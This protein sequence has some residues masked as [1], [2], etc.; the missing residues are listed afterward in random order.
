MHIAASAIPMMSA[1]APFYYPRAA[2][3]HDTGGVSLAILGGCTAYLLKPT[4]CL[5]TGCVMFVAGDHEGERW[6]IYRGQVSHEHASAGHCG[7]LPGITSLP[8]LFVC[9]V[10]VLVSLSCLSVSRPSD[11]RSVCLTLRL[12]AF[13]H[14]NLSVCVSDCMPVCLP[15]CL[16]VCLSD[17]P[18]VCPSVCLTVRLLAFLHNNLS[19]CMSVCLIV[20]LC[21]CLPVCLSV[22]LSVCLSGCLSICLPDSAFACFSACQPSCLSDCLP[23]C[24]ST[25]LSICL[26]LCPSVSGRQE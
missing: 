22:W 9:P 2:P 20:C 23:A 15:A 12:L 19:V 5:L 11:V 1:T 8:S 10:Y 7:P 18:S 4:C 24:L 6:H 25:C 16:S 13:P 3:Y 14:N 26:S 17:C 21:V